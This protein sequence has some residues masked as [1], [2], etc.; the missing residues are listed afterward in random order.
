MDGCIDW[1][2]CIDAEGYGRT[3]D[4]DRAHRVAFRAAKGAIPEGLILDHLCRNRR[5]VNADHLEAVTRAENTRRGG[6]AMQT[7]CI[8]GHPFDEANTYRYRGSRT[9]RACQCRRVLRYKRR[10]R[11]PRPAGVVS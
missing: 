9:C 7:S 6:K 10:K 4:H 1:T 5:C 8:R 11:V 3:S 2:G